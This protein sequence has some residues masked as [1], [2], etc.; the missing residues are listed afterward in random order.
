V[1]E[2]YKMLSDGDVSDISDEGNES[3]DDNCFPIEE[4]DN[5]LD[6]LDV[7]DLNLL[8]PGIEPT[9]MVE[10]DFNPTDKRVIRWVQKPSKPPI[11]NLE[12]IDNEYV[13]AIKTPIQYF[14]EYFRDVIFTKISFN[15]NL[16]ATQKNLGSMSNPPTNMR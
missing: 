2:I 9:V 13:N 5:L 6:E 16:Y 4:L 3:F 7:S 14:S 11:I 15:I 10:P 1:L 8:D 12:N